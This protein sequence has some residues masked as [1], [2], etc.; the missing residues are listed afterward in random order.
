MPLQDHQRRGRLVPERLAS[1]PRE[2]KGDGDG[3]GDTAIGKVGVL[4][5]VE[6]EGVTVCS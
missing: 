5:A 6:E 3:P 4:E 2:G 1:S